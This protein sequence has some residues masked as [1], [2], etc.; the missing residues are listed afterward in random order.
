MNW[1]IGIAIAIVVL[2]AFIFFVKIVVIPLA[3]V[4]LKKRA[5]DYA[6]K[7]VGDIASPLT[8]K[9]V[10]NVTQFAKDQIQ[11]LTEKKEEESKQ[12]ST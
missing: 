2:V 11:N 9:A 7:R 12:D 10:E 8:K 6:K 4:Y 3:I 1:L 5:F